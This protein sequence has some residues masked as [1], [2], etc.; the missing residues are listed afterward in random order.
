VRLGSGDLYVI[1]KRVEHRPVATD[2]VHLL[3]IEPAGTPYTGDVASF[4]ARCL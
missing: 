1:P 3:L 4:S 2:E